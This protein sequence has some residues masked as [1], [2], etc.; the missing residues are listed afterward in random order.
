MHIT[1]I[2]AEISITLQCANF[3]SNQFSMTRSHSF[4]DIS[5]TWHYVAYFMRISVKVLTKS[6]VSDTSKKTLK[7]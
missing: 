1:P 7:A 3:F 5:K 6:L 4:Y 2:Y